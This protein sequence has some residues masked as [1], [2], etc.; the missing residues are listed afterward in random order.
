MCACNHGV[1]FPNLIT[2]DNG[3]TTYFDQIKYKLCMS[4]MRKNHY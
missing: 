1:N 2:I 3:M 4:Q